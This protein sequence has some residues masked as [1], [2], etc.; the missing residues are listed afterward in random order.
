[1]AL[2]H[3]LSGDERPVMSDLVQFTPRQTPGDPLRFLFVWPGA[4]MAISDVAKGYS[5]ALKAAGHHLTDYI[6]TKRLIYHI[7]ATRRYAEEAGN[8]SLEDAKDDVRLMAKMASEC[9]L[10][11]AIYC[12]ADAVIIVSGLNL[13][14]GVLYLLRWAGIPVVCVL[15]ESPYED[16][17]QGEW[18]QSNSEAIVFT[19]ERHSASTNAGW[20]YLPCAYDPEVHKEVD[21]D[22][23]VGCDVLFLGSG[24]A[25]RQKFFETVDWTGIDLRLLGP[26]PNMTD[27][28]PLAQFQNGECIDNS[29]ASSY[30]RAAKINLNL[31]RA[32]PHAE[33]TNPR[34]YEVA[35]SGAF[36]VSDYRAEIPEIFGSSIPTFRTAS[37]LRHLIDRYVADEPMRRRL[38]TEAQRR[39]AKH[40]FA[41]RAESLVSSLRDVL[42]SRREA[43]HSQRG[44]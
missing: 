14:P 40:T 12:K 41:L 3:E 43:G 33:S 2:D 18:L 13:W 31:H 30:Y 44:R 21:P 27:D 16:V 28:S 22:L 26:W 29:L 32:H 24:F 25:D 4:E 7:S 39:V 8:R 15:T 20:S 37:E 36:Q 19:N 6:L 34:T 11:E 9:V 38:A 42:D 23:S 10:P 1:M 35:A 5:S 17:E